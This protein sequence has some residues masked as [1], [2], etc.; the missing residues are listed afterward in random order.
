M[1]QLPSWI[2][3]AN[4]APYAAQGIALGLRAAE[5]RDAAAYRQAQMNAQAAARQQQ[6]AIEQQRQ[7]VREELAQQELA[8]RQQQLGLSAE[9]IALHGALQRA[10]MEEVLRRR[11]AQEE[12]RRR[13]AA[14]ED[15]IKLIMELGPALGSQQTVEAAIIRAQL[16]AAQKKALPEGPLQVRE[17]Q[18]PSGEIVKNWFGAPSATGTGFT[19]HEQ[20]AG[21]PT[22]TEAQRDTA[23]RGAQAMILKLR[24]DNPTLFRKDPKTYTPAEQRIADTIDAWENR[25]DTLRNLDLTGATAVSRTGTTPPGAAA[26]TAGLAP[27]V[28][29]REQGIAV[30]RTKLGMGRV[31]IGGPPTVP[32]EA[33]PPSGIGPGTLRVGDLSISRQVKPSGAAA[34]PP[35]P[36]QE[37]EGGG[38]A[39]PGIV[40]AP[41]AAPGTLPTTAGSLADIYRGYL[42]RREGLGEAMSDTVAGLAAGAVRSPFGQAFADIAEG[43]AGLADLPAEEATGFRER[44]QALRDELEAYGLPTTESEGATALPAW[45]DEI[46]WE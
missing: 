29:D 23:M 43:I 42:R 11:A 46:G 4:P 18:L 6:L 32:D 2:R 45:D 41:P 20:R 36:T 25:L 35:W 27:L 44:L 19:V 7:A 38:A 34:A 1:P 30:P 13:A 15:P 31:S 5:Q 39:I 16:A 14:G 10:Q 3:A 21:R 33:L 37:E 17:L 9:Q 12:Y 8:L 24:E 22:M 28:F 40:P 26:D